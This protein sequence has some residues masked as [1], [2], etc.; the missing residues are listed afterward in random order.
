MSQDNLADLG[1]SPFFASAFASLNSSALTPARVARAEREH[2]LLMHALGVS[3]AVLSG[4]LRHAALGP[5]DLPVVGDWVAARL[6]DASGS[7]PSGGTVRIEALLPR[8]TLLARLESGGRSQSQPLAANADLVLLAAGLD[9][10]FNPRR[11]E[12]GVALA[13]TAGAE[14]VVVLTK[15]DL[16]PD[17]RREISLAMAVAPG[18]Q[19]LAL[20]SQTGEGIEELRALLAPGVT[21]VLLGSSGAGKSTLVN[22]LLGCERQRTAQVREADSRGRHAT[23]HRELFPLPGGGLLMDTPGLRAFGLT[24]GEDMEEL[25]ADVGHFAATCR[26]PDCRHEAEPDCGVKTAVDQ[27]RLTPERYRAYLKLRRE[28]ERMERRQAEGPD[29]ETKRRE[30]AFGKMRKR[31]A[32]LYAKR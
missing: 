15:A 23:T 20:S 29:L 17:P 22:R 32:R 5:G 16:R 28:A 26:F 21:A 9:H 4:K 24:G 27:G 8:R 18:A 11:L 25:F 1:W 31:C 6:D 19:I 14:P 30:K 10:D 3:P 13:F 7:D 2:F 12:R